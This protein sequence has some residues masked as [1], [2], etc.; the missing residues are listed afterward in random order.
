M[1]PNTLLL[2]AVLLSA[3][4]PPLDTGAPIET[5]V[6][7][8]TGGGAAS[9]ELGER[10]AVAS[11][12]FGRVLVREQGYLLGFVSMAQE[13]LL[14]GYDA[15]WR[16]TGEEYLLSEP[17]P[18]EPDMELADSDHGL[19][20]VR[21]TK[22]EDG[23][24]AELRLFDAELAEQASSGHL[25]QGADER[26]LD[27]S[28][29]V[30][31][32]RVWLGTEYRGDGEAWT[33]NIPPEPELPRGLLLRE[34]SLDLDLLATHRLTATIPEA[35]P[36]GQFWGLGAAQLRDDD[37]HW[38]FAAAASGATEHFDEGESAGTRRIW[39]LEYDLDLTLR[40]V[41]GPLTPADQ[42]AYWCT[43][44]RRHEDQLV[45]SYTFRRP[46]DGSVLGPPMP[47]GGNI[48]LLLADGDH[49]VLQRIELTAHDSTAINQGQGAHRSSITMAGEH[50]WVS[51][52][53]P[54]AIQV[55][56]LTL[57]KP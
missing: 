23:P 31:A 44:A 1:T 39:A 47:D 32:D 2:S 53:E 33:D 22:D 52:D 21:L 19:F 20:H 50:I 8:D 54:G 29:M 35:S 14:H 48:G 28:L 12:A 26:A 16:P 10:V 40:A 41:H 13:H 45:L 3:C 37:A 34:L 11:G 49:R 38:V 18:I 51:W 25:Q 9:L 6:P 7:G 4:S 15:T 42:D 27:A 55:Q 43:G 24:G 5:D 17:G 36:Q 46:E 56:E 57:V 30:S